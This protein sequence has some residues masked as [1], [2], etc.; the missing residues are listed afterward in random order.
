MRV[1]WI[2]LAVALGLAARCSGQKSNPASAA[3]A[4]RL[5]RPQGASLLQC[6]EV[7]VHTK[8]VNLDV[9]CVT[10]HPCGAV[11]GYDVP[12][13]FPRERPQVEYTVG[14]A[15]AVT[16]CTVACHSP[17]GAPSRPLPGIPHVAGLCST[18]T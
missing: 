17:M 14:V 11:F 16:T 10:C 9:G 15:P 6:E 3:I 8:H 18:A 13:T 2:T 4:P 12:Y 7:D 5:A 1:A